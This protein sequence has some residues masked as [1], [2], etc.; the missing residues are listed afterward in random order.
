[1]QEH[2]HNQHRMALQHPPSRPST[3][4]LLLRVAAVLLACI[5]IWKIGMALLPGMSTPAQRL[6]AGTIITALACG[7]LAMALR[8]DRL[9]AS[10]LGL[11]RIRD[12]LIGAFAG[13]G[14]WLLTALPATVLLLW[15]GLASVQLAS[16][17]PSALATLAI[18]IPAV[19]LIEAI[20]EELLF[21]GYLQGTLARR[22]SPWLSVIAQAVLF[23]SFA[24]AIGATAAP[25]Q[26]SFL[27]GF[28]LILGGLR[29]LGGN[30]GWPI[31]FHAAL[32][33]AT[34]WLLAHGHFSVG[35]AMV[36][37]AIAFVALPSAVYGVVLSIRAAGKAGR[38]CADAAPSND[39]RPARKT[40]A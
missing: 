29:L 3:A 7:T 22:L 19:L 1:M 27:P 14:L 31:G 6:L 33:I 26:W 15:L 10:L 12:V 38:A 8:M 39:T 35:N 25:G 24:W 28:A 30:L 16:D 18:L 32:M 21:R 11:G 5:A 40:G 20:P 36:I 17:W 9:D 37:Q 34:Q 13:A 23:V 2:R 4:G